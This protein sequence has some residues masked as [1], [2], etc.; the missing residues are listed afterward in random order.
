MMKKM[1]ALSPDKAELD[2]VRE[3]VAAGK[4]HATVD[5]VQARR[6][7]DELDCPYLTLAPD[8]KRTERYYRVGFLGM[9]VRIGD[10][11]VR[12]E[13]DEPHNGSSLIKLDEV[14]L[15]VV[16]MDE[17]LS[18][19]QHF[20]R[21]PELVR[22]WGMYNYNI[23][24]DTDLRIAGSANLKAFNSLAGREITD[25]VGFF[26][27]AN[28]DSIDYNLG[29]EKLIRHGVPIFVKGRYQGV[30]HTLLPGSNTVSVENVEDAVLANKGS[31]GIE[32]IQSGTTIKEKGLS[33]YGPPLFL[34][35]SLYVADYHRYQKSEKFRRLLAYLKPL[36]YF[37][38]EHI[39]N[40]VAWFKA[41]AANLQDSWINK[42]SPG[43]I[44]C[45]LEEMKNGL[46]PYRLRTRGWVPSDNYKVEEAV[47]LVLRSLALIEK[48]YEKPRI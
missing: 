21:C 39:I 48:E 6:Y 45:T 17:L 41:L 42:P 27:I 31:V 30:V 19:N 44:F 36:G 10:L 26:L 47:A 3:L 2:W 24:K 35:E 29:Y 43:E 12:L 22:K 4:K 7:L 18:M 37:D 9:E 28:R 32:I 15:T 40:Y 13:G 11:V 38:R 5:P 16:G 8:R 1:A 25:F 23:D 34:S 20:L 14:D 33:V 46:R